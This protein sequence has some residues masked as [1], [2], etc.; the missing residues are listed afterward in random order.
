MDQGSRTMTKK[1]VRPM[2]V[3]DISF[4]P[5]RPMTEKQ[6]QEYYDWVVNVHIAD[7][8]DETAMKGIVCYRKTNKTGFLFLMEFDSEEELQKF[9]TSVERDSLTAETVSLYPAG[10]NE[11]FSSRIGTDYLSGEHFLKNGSENS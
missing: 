10:P 5:K 7:L 4:N 11:Y 8:F 2:R 3:L 9:N 6:V 1:T